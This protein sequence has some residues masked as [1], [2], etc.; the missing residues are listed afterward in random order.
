M[1]IPRNLSAK[2]LI[3]ILEGHGY[4]AIRTSGSH[5]RMTHDGPPRHSITVPTHGALKIGTLNAILTSVGKHLK[6]DKQSI[7]RDS[8]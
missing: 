1:T 5:V 6:M 4:Q 8:R 7:L 3:K 2:K